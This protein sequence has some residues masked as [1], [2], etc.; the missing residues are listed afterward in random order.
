MNQRHITEYLSGTSKL[1]EA[2]TG[3]MEALVKEYPY[4]HMAHLMFTKTLFDQN[5]IHYY[6]QLKK[7]AIHIPDRSILYWLTAGAAPEKAS[8][9]Q[10][11]SVNPEP[12][13]PVLIPT[14]QEQ[15][16]KPEEATS[17]Y[18]ILMARLEKLMQTPVPDTDTAMKAL[19]QVSNM[20][21]A[22]IARLINQ[23][24]EERIRQEQEYAAKTKPGDP[25][26]QEP[27][28]G[29]EMHPPPANT[30]PEEIKPADVP[31]SNKDLIEQFISAQ[32]AMPRPKKEF[33]NPVNIAHQSTVDDE[34]L[35]TETLAEVHVK[36][37][38]IEKAL[39]IYSKLCLIFPEKSTYFAARI[40]N[41][42]KENNL[43]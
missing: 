23:Y 1:S 43:L 41:L 39:K 19:Q 36:Q 6:A 38:N 31:F 10:T 37:G 30:Q 18:E 27:D 32:P 40:E 33:F 22:R 2:D 7:S 17:A 9:M 5:S 42:K 35:V 4:C 15:G 3:A 34:S 16:V 12:A 14:G 20:H 21:E 25:S 24:K 13:P 8:L 29:Q 11:G 26:R 28:A